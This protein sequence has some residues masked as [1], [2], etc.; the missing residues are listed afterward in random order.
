MK[1]KV[2]CGWKQVSRGGKKVKQVSVKKMTFASNWAEDWHRS[3]LISH[4]LSSAQ[5][6]SNTVVNK[7]L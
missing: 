1:G 7:Q 3:I 2:P 4:I 5:Q 6:G